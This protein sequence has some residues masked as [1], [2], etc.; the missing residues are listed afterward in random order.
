MKKYLTIFLTLT[1][2]L[3]FFTPSA[4]AGEYLG[5]LTVINCQSFVTL[6]SGPSTSAGEVTRVPRGATVEAYYYNSQFAECYYSG[7]HG[8]ILTTYLSIGNGTASSQSSD[9]MGKRYIVNCNEFVT[10]RQYAD[11]SAPTV[12][13]VAKG[14]QVDAYYYDGTFCRCFYNGLEGYILSVYLSDA[15][16]GGTPTTPHSDSTQ[17]AGANS[18]YVPGEPMGTMWVVNCREWVSMW[19]YASKDAPRI[20]TVPLGASVEATWYNYDFAECEYRGYTGYILLSY[21]SKTKG[22]E[23]YGGGKTNT[24]SKYTNTDNSAKDLSNYDYRQVVEYGRGALV[25]QKSPK[26]SFMKNF[27]YHDGDWIYVNLNWRK[28]GYAI[29]Y[30]NGT[31]GYVDASYID[32]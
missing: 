29:A 8:Y 12:T 19:E 31:Y 6:R 30:E 13:K 24:S 23:I 18:Y 22:S 27:K 21:L 17:P 20:T 15:P 14:Q 11:R 28:D 1:L 2:V 9:Y 25:F 4:L 5:Y 7:M 26:G 3:C 16:Y 10:L 32:W